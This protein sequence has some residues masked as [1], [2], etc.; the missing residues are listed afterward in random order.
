MRDVLWKNGEI[1]IAHADIYV[2]CAEAVALSR[3]IT[4]ILSSINLYMVCRAY[5]ADTHGNDS[6]DTH[7]ND[8]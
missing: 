4:Y 6:A 3:T 1:T 5:D 8:S 7:G 2:H